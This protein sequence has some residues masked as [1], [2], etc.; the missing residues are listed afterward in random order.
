V[1]VLLDE[2]VPV[3]LAPDLVGHE[4]QTVSGLGWAGVTNSELLRRA[5][6]AAL[7]QTD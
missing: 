4:V 6:G 7:V 5:S 1:R 2:N 3:G